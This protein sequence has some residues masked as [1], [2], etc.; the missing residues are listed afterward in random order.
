MKKKLI[1][2]LKVILIPI[3][4]YI[5]FVVFVLFSTTFPIHPL[6]QDFHDYKTLDNWDLDTHAVGDFDSDGITDLVTFTGCAFLSSVNN[7][8]IPENKKCI[9]T[10]IMEIF[11]KNPQYHIGQKFIDTNNTDLTLNQDGYQALTYAYLG[12]SKD[13]LW[14][15]Y[16]E[17]ENKMV[18]W[19]I[20]KNKLITKTN[21]VP[22]AT[23]LDKFIYQASLISVTP[24]FYIL[25]Y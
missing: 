3:F 13:G 16:S 9:A 24:I 6:I 15:I 19:E 12:K 20:R 21:N 7:N 2:P 4:L 23:Y 14:R 8:S 25:N 10:G 22:L 5:F 18:I 1:F 17:H 11:I